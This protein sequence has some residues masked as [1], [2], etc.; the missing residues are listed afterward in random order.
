ML[1]RGGHL[2]QAEEGEGRK[3]DESEVSKRSG[4]REKKAR[5]AMVTKLLITFI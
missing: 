1:A 3:R 4:E 5:V 2:L